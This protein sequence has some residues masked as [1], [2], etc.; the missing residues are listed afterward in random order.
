MATQK[1]SPIT[2]M[3]KLLMF[4]GSGAV[5][6]QIHGASLLSKSYEAVGIRAEPLN[7][8]SLPWFSLQFRDW[9]TKVYNLPFTARVFEQCHVQRR[10]FAV[11]ALESFSRMLIDPQRYAFVAAIVAAIRIKSKNTSVFAF[12]PDGSRKGICLRVNRHWA[13]AF[14]GLHCQNTKLNVA[15]CEHPLCEWEVVDLYQPVTELEAV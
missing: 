14:K 10:D 1:V 6:G 8:C 15:L 5:S 9:M 4:E 7:E 12:Q 2:K 3:V 13:E 11:Q